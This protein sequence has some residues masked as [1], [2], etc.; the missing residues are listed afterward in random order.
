[1]GET[2]DED[3]MDPAHGLS[4]RHVESQFQ[5]LRPKHTGEIAR[6]GRIAGTSKKPGTTS[7]MRKTAHVT[8]VARTRTVDELTYAIQSAGN[9]KLLS[10]E[11]RSEP[12]NEN[13]RRMADDK[14]NR[15][16]QQICRLAAPAGGK[17]LSRKESLCRRGRK[18]GRPNDE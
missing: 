10:S 8:N 12:F 3:A 16:A 11:H 2:K 6:R 4:V 5:T 15:I 9:W 14:G 17:T 7:P 1:M 18:L 13:A